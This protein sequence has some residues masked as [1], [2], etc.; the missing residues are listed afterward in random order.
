MNQIKVLHVW[1]F[2][3][4]KVKN[5]CERLVLLCIPKKNK[6]VWDDNY[7]FEKRYI[8]LIIFQ[9]LE[10]E[11]NLFWIYFCFGFGFED[12]LNA[13]YAITLNNEIYFC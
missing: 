6:T 5:E 8:M 3:F 10:K 7:W 1:S 9:G 13:F 4:L 11:N 12:I 2:Y